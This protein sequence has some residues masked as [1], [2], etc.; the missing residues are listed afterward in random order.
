M[1][2]RSPQES[3][4][5]ICPSISHRNREFVSMDSLLFG[6]FMLLMFHTMGYKKKTFQK[7]TIHLAILC[8]PFGLVKRPPTRGSKG[9]FE[10]PGG[11]LVFHRH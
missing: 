3:M 1:A 8:D 10:S 7:K 11:F 6:D 5:Q 9:H 2:T 4:G